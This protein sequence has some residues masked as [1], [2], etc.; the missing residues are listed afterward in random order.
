MNRF[1]GL[2]LVMLMT[3][4]SLASEQSRPKRAEPQRIEIAV[5]RSHDADWKSVPPT[6]VFESGDR[7]RFRV[8]TNFDGY[9]YVI[10]LGTSGEYAILFP[11]DETGKANK[12]LSGSDYLIPATESYFKI[13]GPPGQ[14]VVYWIV[15]PVDI[16]N[17]QKPYVPLAPPPKNRPANL[18]PRC[19]ETV[20]RARGLCTDSTAG[21]RNLT[22]AEGTPDS[23][24][25]MRRVTPRDI[26]IR[27]DRNRAVVSSMS[28]SVGPVVYEFRVA[29][30]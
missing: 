4:P 25:K 9:L 18:S 14:D 29:H 17:G 26:V 8:R 22:E 16:T 3:V 28:D 6:L 15:S 12:V 10:N 11:R 7:L 1:L 24:L 19:D 21:P 27:N 2:Q 23:I 13:A 5:E 20:L 30:K